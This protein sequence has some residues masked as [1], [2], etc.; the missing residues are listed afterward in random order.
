MTD[1][2]D[3]RAERALRGAVETTPIAGE[4]DPS[5]A[6]ARA[7]RTRAAIGAGVG[8]VALIMIIA[9]VV[10]VPRWLGERP[11][12]L[13][14]GPPEPAATGYTDPAP[15]GWRT[16]QYRGITVQVPSSWGYGYEPTDQWCTSEGSGSSPKARDPYVA[17]G[18]PSAGTLVLCP[19]I[20]DR[21]V[22]E[23]LQVAV[24]DG[25]TASETTV[26]GHWV[27]TRVVDGVQVKGVSRDKALAQRI[28]DSAQVASAEEPCAPTMSTSTDERPDPAFVVDRLTVTG[29][30]MVCQ[31]GDIPAPV[32]EAQLRARAILSAAEL[33]RL[34]Q[35]IGASPAM[36]ECP[37]T[38]VGHGVQLV[39][40][41]WI[42][43]SSGVRTLAVRAGSCGDANSTPLGGFDDGTTVHRL[44][45]ATCRQVLV[46]PVQFQSGS[47]DVAEGC[48]PD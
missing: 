32:G 33:T 20:P 22:T 26:N 25:A 8:V 48:A 45:R 4:V 2:A 5:Y 11:G 31:Y 40:S 18:T 1:P 34:T 17:L 47:G 12:D 29:A 24:V 28:V 39:L 10:L 16:E 35:Q 27:I 44:V 13:L 46:E 41:V 14:V 30:G 23:H 19:P 21:L 9:G 3:D 6:R 38:I 7:G 15:K 37:S 42:P 43:T 36:G